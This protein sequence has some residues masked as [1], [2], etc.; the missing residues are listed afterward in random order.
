[1]SRPATEAHAPKKEAERRGEEDPDGQE[2]D[3]ADEAVKKPRIVKPVVVAP[4]V[5]E[6]PPVMVEVIQGNSRSTVKFT[7]EGR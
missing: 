1:M 2:Q 3:R 5:K 4:P 7:E 6:A